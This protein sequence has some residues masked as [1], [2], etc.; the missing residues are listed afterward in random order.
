M[1]KGACRLGSNSMRDARSLTSCRRIEV[2]VISWSQALISGPTKLNYA[3]ASQLASARIYSNNAHSSHNAVRRAA[4]AALCNAA[5]CVC[6]VYSVSM[7]TT[8]EAKICLRNGRT[9]WS[10]RAGGPQLSIA[11]DQAHYSQP[12]VTT[13][14]QALPRA[15]QPRAGVAGC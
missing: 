5:L 8:G 1:L 13:A 2:A 3:S 12:L 9:H 14:H 11:L 15:A 10:G 6:W 4:S 7:F